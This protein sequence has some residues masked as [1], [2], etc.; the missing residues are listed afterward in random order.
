MNET[1][2]G[3]RCFFIIL[4]TTTVVVISDL[5]ARTF[6]NEEAKNITQFLPLLIGSIALC[7][8]GIAGRNRNKLQPPA[9]QSNSSGIRRVRVTGPIK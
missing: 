9:N 4:I 3:L 2:D 7:A 8:M 1:S 5:I 6:F